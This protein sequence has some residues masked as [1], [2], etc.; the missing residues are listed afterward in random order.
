MPA[1]GVLLTTE[2]LVV[3]LFPDELVSRVDMPCVRVLAVSRLVTVAP[4]A[5]GVDAM[6]AKVLFGLPM[7]LT[8]PTANIAYDISEVSVA[9]P[10]AVRVAVV[11]LLPKLVP[12]GA[13]WSSGSGEATTPMNSVNCMVPAAATLENLNVSA[14]LITLARQFRGDA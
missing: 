12:A 2:T 6:L 3:T 8:V 10:L 5:N 14:V 11:P 13:V 4:P 7:L 1:H 9:A